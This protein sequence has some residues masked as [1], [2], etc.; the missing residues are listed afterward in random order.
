MSGGSNP[1]GKNRNFR[2][3]KCFGYLT[4][5]RTF[6]T[7]VPRSCPKPTTDEISHLRPCCQE[8]ILSRIKG[9]KIPDY[10]SDLRIYQDSQCTSFISE[11]FSYEGCFQRYPKDEDFVNDDWHIYLESEIV[12]NSYCDTIYLRDR[13]GLLVTQYSYGKPVCR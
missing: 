12:T 7:P 13:D 4:K 10:S 6:T 8:F 9:C 5:S 11:N 1:L 3:N 2:T